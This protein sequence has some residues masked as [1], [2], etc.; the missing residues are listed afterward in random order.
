MEVLRL[1]LRGDLERS[2]FGFDQGERTKFDTGATDHAFGQVTWVGRVF[3]KEWMLECAHDFLERNVWQYNIL[4]DGESCLA[5]A[6]CL[7]KVCQLEQRRASGAPDRNMCT[8]VD[9]AHLLL[10][11]HPKC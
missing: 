8:D 1:E 5:R 6:V 2:R 4:L 11:L 3:G 7:C 9:H 10:A